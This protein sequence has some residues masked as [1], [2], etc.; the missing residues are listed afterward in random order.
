MSKLNMEGQTQVTWKGSAN[1]SPVNCQPQSASLP[2]LGGAT[3]TPSPVGCSNEHGCNSYHMKLKNGPVEPSVLTEALEG[4][5][6]TL[7]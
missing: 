6:G 5:K 2:A 7:L 4:I 3:G 1:N